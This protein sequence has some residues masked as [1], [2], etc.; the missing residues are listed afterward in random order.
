MFP[1]ILFDAFQSIFLFVLVD[2]WVP[3]FIR[4]EKLAGLLSCIQHAQWSHATCGV[5]RGLRINE[6]KDRPQHFNDTSELIVFARSWEERQ[7]EEKFHSDAT[8]RPHIDRGGVRHAKKYF[9]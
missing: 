4:V 5:R 8:K 7:P 6:N 3:Y 2:V 9:R 1:R